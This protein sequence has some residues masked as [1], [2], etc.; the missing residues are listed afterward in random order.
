MCHNI[1]NNTEAFVEKAKEKSQD[2]EFNNFLVGS[3]PNSKII[4]RE[5]VFKGEF[6]LL[7]SESFKS[8]FNREVGKKL[9]EILGKDPN[10][11]EP[12]LLFIYNLKYD[13]FEIE[14]VIKP[15]FIS[16]RYNKYIR[17]IPQTHWGCF[18]CKGKGCD[19]C[20]FT[21][22]QYQF[23]VEEFISPEFLRS[24][25]AEDSKFHGAGREDIDVRM[26]GTGRPFILEL[27]KVKRR[28]SSINLIEI[29]N[30]VNQINEGKVRITDLKFSNKKEVINIKSESQ[31]TRK[32]YEALV[33]AEQP[34]EIGEFQ[35]K[36][37][38]L[39]SKLENQIISQRT[40][41]RVSHRRSDL[42][43]K[44]LIYKIEGEFIKSN[45]YKFTIETQGGTYV[46][47]LIHGD[48]G[49]TSPSVTEVFEIPLICKQLDV[50][51]IKF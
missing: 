44:K 16:G 8:H 24:T 51:E 22:K 37:D 32:V 40:P 2:I 48:E 43:R 3:S 21:G 29:Q 20:N 11:E 13:S 26:L 42:T 46:K 41:I 12:D 1:F 33:E 47:E 45:L 18:K 25:E 34:I 17:G 14:L 36:L 38:Q 4:N 49:R 39:K 27:R 6:S 10:F 30:K 28:K 15:L 19:L 23:S 9:M 35:K 7:E 31:N 5:D 50:I